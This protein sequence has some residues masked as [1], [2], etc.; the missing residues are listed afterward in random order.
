M[1]VEIRPISHDDILGA[2]KCIQES[3]AD[4]PYKNW[5]FDKS[6]VRRPFYL[7]ATSRS[8][9]P[10]GSDEF[11]AYEI[12][13]PSSIPNV[14]LAHSPSAANGV[15]ATRCSMSLK[16]PHHLHRTKFLALLC[17]HR[18]QSRK[19]G[20]QPSTLG[21]FGS[22]RESSIFGSWAMVVCA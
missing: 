6:K 14:T 21:L 5:V 20:P 3:F 22:V 11:R 18:P 2:A 7:H 1:A 10:H 16:I 17:G 19:L 15:Y 9:Q 13:R 12:S 8:R 4:D